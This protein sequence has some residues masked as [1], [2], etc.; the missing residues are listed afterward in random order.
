[1]KELAVFDEYTE[2]TLQWLA[3]EGGGVGDLH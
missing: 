1:L 3:R 2:M